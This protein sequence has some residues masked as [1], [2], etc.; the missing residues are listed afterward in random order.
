MTF[1]VRFCVLKM[2]AHTISY[3]SEFWFWDAKWY[4][5]STIHNQLNS[6]ILFYPRIFIS[7]WL[8][9]SMKSNT[10]QVFKHN[11]PYSLQSYITILFYSLDFLYNY[12]RAYIS[13]YMD[14]V[15]IVY[16]LLFLKKVHTSWNVNVT[17]ICLNGWFINANIDNCAWSV[18]N[19]HTLYLE[20]HIGKKVFKYCFVCLNVL[21][22]LNKVI[23]LSYLI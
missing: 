17:L 5:L 19:F 6:F 16:L 10:V 18:F 15:G 9:V 7:F 20:G 11:F 14:L 21:P 3:S 13:N 8:L 4:L 2:G 1:N 23:I 22:S 12:V